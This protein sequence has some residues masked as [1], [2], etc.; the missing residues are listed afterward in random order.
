MRGMGM[1]MMMNG[2]PSDTAAA[3]KPRAAEADAVTRCPRPDQKLVDRGRAVFSTTGNCYACHGPNASG[4]VLAPNL[5]DATWLN[6]DGSYA[7]IVELVRKGVPK[8]KEHQ[9]PMPPEG[10]ASLSE[11]QVCAVAAYV[12]SL[13]HR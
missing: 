10:G 4:T 11:S 8:P 1:P 7:S 13:G 5:T 3:P 6:I 12:F 9:A 2:A